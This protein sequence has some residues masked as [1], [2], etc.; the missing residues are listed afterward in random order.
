MNPGKYTPEF[1]TAME[2]VLKDETGE[3]SFCD[4]SRRDLYVGLS[5]DRA[6]K[7]GLGELSALTSEQIVKAYYEKVWQKLELEKLPPGLGYFMLDCG[8]RFGEDNAWNWLCFA[9]E[10]PPGNTDKKL[11]WHLVSLKTSRDVVLLIDSYVRRRLKVDAKWG[12]C[13]H[14]WTNR[15]NRARDRAV[16]LNRGELL[17]DG[18]DGRNG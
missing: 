8:V 10:L 12:L 9:L 17:G 14:W 3:E 15:A 13:K 4:P 6:S 7:W 1:C 11:V 2:L 5:A 18:T 16:K